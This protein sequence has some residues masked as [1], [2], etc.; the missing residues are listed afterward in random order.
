MKGRYV[1]DLLTE[2]S[3]RLIQEKQDDK[4]IFLLL[5]HLAPHAGNLANKFEYLPQDI[6]RFNYIQD[7]D[8]R[9]F[10]GN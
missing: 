7:L 1:T 4:P 9:K 6:E 8:R 5:S 10:A 3:V 2:E